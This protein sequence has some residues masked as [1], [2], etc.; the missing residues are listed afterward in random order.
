L[1]VMR[2]KKGRAVSDPPLCNRI[3]GG[4]S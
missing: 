4:F 3:G 2:N 1:L